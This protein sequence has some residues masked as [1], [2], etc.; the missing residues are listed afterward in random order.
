MNFENSKALVPTFGE[1]HL[2]V[3]LKY[4]EWKVMLAVPFI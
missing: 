2:L 3:L 1:L 4:W